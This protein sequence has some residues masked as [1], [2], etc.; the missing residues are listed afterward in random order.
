MGMLSATIFGA[1]ALIITWF[2]RFYAD[3]VRD[4]RN[5]IHFAMQTGHPEGMHYVSGLQLNIDGPMRWNVNFVGG[6]KSIVRIASKIMNF[7]PPLVADDQ[8]LRLHL[9]HTR[10]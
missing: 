1:L 7:P 5:Q 8:Y 6:C 2:S 10:G 9:L 3:K 4:A